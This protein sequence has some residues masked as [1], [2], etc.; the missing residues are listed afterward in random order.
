MRLFISLV[1]FIF[2]HFRPATPKSTYQFKLK[3]LIKRSRKIR[4][5][6]CRYQLARPLCLGFN[7]QSP[8][9]HSNESQT[10][11][12]RLM[13][14]STIVYERARELMQY[15]PLPGLFN[16]SIWARLH[17]TPLTAKRIE[18]SRLQWKQI[19]VPHTNHLLLSRGFT[20]TQQL[21]SL[22]SVGGKR[23][24]E[25]YLCYRNRI[26]NPITPA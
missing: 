15:F 21:L 7:P 8:A 6:L 9:Y 2:N 20:G 1:L 12:V 10:N 11:V 14:N 5:N 16:P 4:Q 24:S 17:D 23:E 13:R 3:Q 26:F 19:S 22:W 25:S 18:R